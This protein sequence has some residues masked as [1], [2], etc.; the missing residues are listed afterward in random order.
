MEWHNHL[1][2]RKKKIQCVR[3]LRVKSWLTSSGKVNESLSW[4]SW[5]GATTNSERDVQKLKKSKQRIRMVRPNRKIDEVLLP[6]WQ[7]PTAHQSAH[8]GGNYNNRVDCSPSSSLQ[9][10]FST[11]RLPPFSPVK[12]A[13]GGQPLAYN[14][15]LK[16]N[17]CEEL[18][19][20]SLILHRRTASHAK[21]ERV[22]W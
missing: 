3:L 11:P 21:V 8:E 7:H 15:E 13:L 16:H 9:S 5:R 19:R 17:V 22:S 10:R 20:F 6:V 14:R 1:S 18:R 12:D 2:L 4:N